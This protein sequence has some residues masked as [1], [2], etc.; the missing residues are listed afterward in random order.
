MYKNDVESL[1]EASVCKNKMQE[2]LGNITTEWDNLKIA[3]L[4]RFEQG[5]WP[6]IK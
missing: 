4:P 2:N 1:K 3:T 6:C 5:S